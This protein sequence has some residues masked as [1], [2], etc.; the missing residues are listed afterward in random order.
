MRPHQLVV[1][2]PPKVMD[3]MDEMK[4]ENAEMKKVKHKMKFELKSKT[5]D[6]DETRTDLINKQQNLNDIKGTLDR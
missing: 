2:R 6:L 4:K 5:D 3:E 1:V